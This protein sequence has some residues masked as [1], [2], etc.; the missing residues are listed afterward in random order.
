MRSKAVITKLL[1]ETALS[2]SA[3]KPI[4]WMRSVDMNAD[5]NNSASITRKVQILGSAHALPQRCVLSSE[6][7]EQ[8]GLSAGRIE[9]VGGV[10]QRYFA[11]ANENAATLA[12]AAG[13]KALLAA[14][15]TLDDIDCL[16]ATSAT[17]DQGMPS[18]GA[19]IHKELGLSAKGIPAFDINASCL[20]F[21]AALDTLTYMLAAGH[22]KRILVVAADL[23]SC[24][25]NWDDLESSAIFGDGAAAVVLGQSGSED[26]S[27][28]LATSFKTFSE[29]VHFCE[30]PG[31]G[32]R[33]HPSRIEQAFNPLTKF[34]MDGKKVFRLACDHMPK[35]VDDLLLSADMSLAEVDWIVPHQAS[36]L[37][38]H[39]LIKRLN[40]NCDKVINIFKNHGNQ[41]AA[42]LPTALDIAIA[43]ARIQRG[44]T[45]LLLG[46]GAGLSM[47]AALMVY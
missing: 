5:N 17:M 35:F 36:Q 12:A 9:L 43:D 21:L 2:G 6:L 42:S 14:N 37:A 47:G 1:I 44:D 25:L 24:G 41:V 28:L 4:L 22:H 32:S 46:T 38:I 3:S 23:A 34:H 40:F 31:G 16:V 7:D 45:L 39:H 13:R 19:L 29:G 20:G 18:N 10:H 27:V 33:Y 30:I 15:L 26:E 11:G 8:L